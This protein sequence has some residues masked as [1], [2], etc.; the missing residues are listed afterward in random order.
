MGGRDCEPVFPAFFRA[1]FAA[2]EAQSEKFKK[3]PQ[4][5]EGE[6][7]ARVCD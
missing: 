6:H 5:E 3:K 1:R 4:E 2:A 7:S